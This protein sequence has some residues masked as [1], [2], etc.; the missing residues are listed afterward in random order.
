MAHYLVTGGCGFI[1]SHLVDALIAA[2]H[3]VRVV[4][5]LSTGHVKNISGDVELIVGDLRH[6]SVIDKVVMGVDGIFHLAAVA[7]ITRCNEHW[8]DCHQVNQGAMVALFDACRRLDASLPI[9]Y[10]SSAAVY[11][12]QAELPLHEELT[13]APLGPYGVDKAGCELQARAAA[14]V[15]RIRSFGLRFF[16]VYGDRQSADNAYAGV[17]TAFISRSRAGCE[18]TVNGDGRQTLRFRLRS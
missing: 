12:D 14:T 8:L 9:V 11:G 1:G 7:S 16:N 4:D 15:H 6:S 10:A 13:P 5:N 2:N 17:I 3:T 18:L